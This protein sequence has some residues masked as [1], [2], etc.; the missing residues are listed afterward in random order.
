MEVPCHLFHGEEVDI[1]KT[2]TLIVSLHTAQ[3]ITNIK[4]II[5]EGYFKKETAEIIKG[6]TNEDPA[7]LIKIKNPE[8]YSG[9]KSG[10]NALVT[11]DPVTAIKIKHPET[12]DPSTPIKIE[13]PETYSGEKSS[14]NA[15]VSEDTALKIENPETN[16][17]AK[18]SDNALDDVNS[19]ICAATDQ[20]QSPINTTEALS[21]S[22]TTILPLYLV[23]E[24]LIS[25]EYL[26]ESISIVDRDNVTSYVYGTTSNSKA[27]KF[28]GE[29]TSAKRY[30]D[31]EIKHKKSHEV[32]WVKLGK[33]SLS[34]FDKDG[35][36]SGSRLNVRHINHAHAMIKSQG[37]QC[38]LFQ[39]SLYSLHEMKYRFF[40]PEVII[41]L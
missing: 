12:E 18:S 34:K 4:I 21:S 25:P 14:D 3:L 2:R 17:N 15:L 20:L 26:R 33:S 22:H 41:G 1:E 11:K 29:K 31:L 27:S 40:I 35:I 6:G 9:D 39:N 8:A 19:C 37:L 32:Q 38:T 10:D 16:S 30:L 24:V 28:Y 7:T 36:D 23:Q 5:V 13:D